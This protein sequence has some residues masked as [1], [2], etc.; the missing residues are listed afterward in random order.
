MGNLGLL[1]ENTV[2]G[3]GSFNRRMEEVKID[4]VKNA[5]LSSGC[6]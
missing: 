6:T 3:G 1:T 2:N 5:N 4:L